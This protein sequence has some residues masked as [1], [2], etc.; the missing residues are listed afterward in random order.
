VLAKIEAE[1]THQ[2]VSDNENKSRSPR[3]Q[4]SKGF[5]PEARAEFVKKLKEQGVTTMIPDGII[6]GRKLGIFRRK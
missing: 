6:E 4:S 2:F 1:H 3:S 5:T